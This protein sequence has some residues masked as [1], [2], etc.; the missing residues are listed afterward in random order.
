MSPR[1][2]TAAGLVALLLL[3]APA[4]ATDVTHQPASE[5][6]RI[7]PAGTL[8]R[9]AATHEAAV[10]ALPVALVRSPDATGPGGRGRYLVAVNSGFGVQFSAATNRAQ[11][12]LTVI[13]LAADPPVA[14]QNVYFPA[15]Q[16]ANV[17]AVFAP[18]ADADGAWPFYVSGG[19]ENT[20]WVFAFRPGEDE[21]LSPPSPGPATRVKAPGIDLAAMA[22][23]PASKAI[24]GGRPSVY[25]AGLALSPDGGTL[26]TANNLGDSLGI[27]S[28]LGGT[29]RVRAVPL[30]APGLQGNLYP[31]G[32][33]VVPDGRSGA[34]KVYVSLW[35]ASAVAVVRPDEDRPAVAAIPVAGHPTAMVL[36]AAGSRLYVADANADAVSVI[37]TVRDVE[38]ERID[39]R[40]AETAL[41]GATPEDLALDD[42]GGLLYVANAHANAVAVVALSPRAR[43]EEASKAGREDDDDDLGDAPG[44][45]RVAGFIP[46]GQ[47]PSA[48]AVVGG[49]LVVGNGKGTGFAD[50]SMTVDDSGRA[51]NTPN[52][53]FPADRAF[54]RGQYI[55]SLIS[56]NFSAI[57][58]P[59]ERR[60]AEYSRQVMEND[61]LVGPSAERLFE[62]RSPITHVIYVIRENRTYDQVFGDLATAGDG[63]RADGDPSLAIFGAGATARVHDGEAQRIT[64]NARA[65]AVR[66]GL[67]D[68]F[69]VN[70][71]ASP[72]GHNW[73]TAAFST[74]YVDKGFRWNYSGRGRSFDFTGFNRLPDVVPPDRIPEQ[75]AHGADA[76]AVAGFLES[77]VPYLHGGTDVAEPETLYLWDAA[78]RAG[79][80]YRNYG[81]FLGTVTTADVAAINQRKRKTYPDTSP[82]AAVVATK[83]SLEGRFSPT[84]AAFDLTIPDAMT[85]AS[86]AASRQTEGAD[87]LIHAA[88]PDPRFR[89]TSRFAAWLEEFDGYVAGLDT[90][91]AGLPA[92]SIVWLPSDH[93]AGLSRGMP[94]PQFMVAD[95]DYALGRLV[96]AVSHSPY[97]KN[98]AIVVVEDDAQAG[99]DHVD[100]HRSVALLISAYNRRGALVHA[101]HSTVSVIRTIELL[102]GLPPMN[103]LDASAAPVDL[104][105]TEPDLTPYTAVLPEVALDNLLVEPAAGART[106]AWIRRTERLDL[107]HPDIADPAVL[108]GAIWY[109]VTGGTLPPGAVASLPAYDL[110]TAGL[111][112]E[113]DDEAA[114]EARRLDAARRGAVTRLV[115]ETRPGR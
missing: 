56:G 50:S 75:L 112:R 32:V 5:G 104:F 40:L 99:P 2:R 44:R 66:F 47:Y 20:V 73:C 94:T 89:G 21:P 35:G 82:V 29:P 76:A 84:F 41:P 52:Y 58:L 14:V 55:V 67:L 91:G 48:I 15:P 108:N 111:L 71:E 64:P 19:F 105:R 96:E 113:D 57:P 78:S 6:R 16:S 88:N 38:V 45:S 93:T 106:A 26:F 37:D 102:L 68:R 62:G 107:S 70:S 69:F 63:S 90:G 7:T 1:I 101:Y 79:L 81:E 28:D 72:D 18:R 92:L 22:A 30:R 54:L 86:Y 95:N 10:G 46:T 27:V 9:D 49:T 83:K 53:R 87:P 23:V 61:G 74:D 43:G 60:L 8:I 109:S 11:Q 85:T 3:A 97:W 39:V 65:L 100:A 33:A 42:A 12:S 13:D 36:N 110:M 31:Y 114:E 4:G 34:A 115:Q 24:N 77:Y 17:G 98:T 51:P 25:P 59:G 80:T 103:Q